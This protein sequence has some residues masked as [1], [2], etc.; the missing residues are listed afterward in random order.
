M[1]V[2]LC[3]RIGTGRPK[4]SPYRPRKYNAMIEEAL[5]DPVTVQMLKIDGVKV[6]E[7]T[8]L[9]PG[10]KI[11]F[12]LHALLEEVLE[13]PSLNTAEYLEKRAKEMSDLPEK[14]LKKLGEKAKEKEE[15]ME[16]KEIKEIRGKYWVQ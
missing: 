7:I 4:E 1:N 12:I 16:E 2:R 3:D 14:E 6:M 10:P 15:E 8:S 5:R 11:G 9:T 13:D